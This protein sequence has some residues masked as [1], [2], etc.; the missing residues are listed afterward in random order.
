[1]RT[2]GAIPL[3]LRGSDWP[4]RLEVRAEVFMTH[5][6]FRELN[7]AQVKRGEK[8]FANPRNAAAGS[9]RQLDPQITARRPLTL[10][11]YGVGLADG[12][13][14]PDRHSAILERLRAWG[15]RVSPEVQV[16][17][18]GVE[19]CLAAYARFAERRDRLPYDIDGVVYKVDRR[20]QQER[21]G[22]VSR[23]PRWAIAHKFPAREEMTRL[24]DIEV[25][26]GRTGALTPVAR[27]E[28]VH[29]GGVTVTSATLHNEDEIERKD[30]RIGDT[31]IVRRAGDVIPEVVGVVASRRPADAQ[32]FRMPERCPVCGSE[33]V[34]LAGEAVARCIGGLVCPAQRKAGIRH[35]ASRRAMDIEGLGEKLVD[36]L[37]ECDLVRSVADL[38]QLD[39]AQLAG[40]ERMGERSAENLVAALERSKETT[41]P[42][43]LFA[44][45]IREVGEATAR[46][47]A[48]HFGTLE[49]LEQAG[50]ETLQEV[51]DVGPVVAQ[52]VAAF[53]RQGH[54]REVIERLRAAGV[55]WPEATPQR[56]ER[57]LAGKIFVLTGALESLTREEATERLQAL[58]AR[59]TGSVSRKTDY[60][61][62]GADPGSKAEKAAR[63]GVETLDEAGLK[64]LLAGEA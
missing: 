60:V 3:R 55:R 49:A 63:L 31:V 7:E 38:Y 10:F 56:G 41:L 57:P 1:V 17:K 24:L 25:Q 5:D 33:V 51:P 40:L 52:S 35:F 13:E 47:L 39:A 30:V 48:T 28:P 62:V 42:R 6:G 8:A 9:L 61:V 45:G 64:R 44:L 59:V 46:A 58:G 12:A 34:R 53:F 27:L 43:F 29:V 11:C 2:I 20:D 54:N 14:L 16:V 22:A 26:V 37:V 50:E 19:G 21:L 23:A 18:E 36:Q 32:R 15:L 4:R